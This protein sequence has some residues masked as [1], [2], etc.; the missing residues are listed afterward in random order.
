MRVRAAAYLLPALLVGTVFAPAVWDL[1][2]SYPLSTYPMFSRYREPIAWVVRALRVEADGR[3]T[4]VAPAVI[5]EG[6]P[7]QAIV[8]LKRTFRRG[9]R[10]SQELCR[11]ILA[12]LELGP[13]EA[14]E[15]RRDYIDAREH[16]A[17]PGAKAKRTRL[18]ARCESSR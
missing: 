6:E 1:D 14:I 13:D 18:V 4:P 8:T 7:M 9:R 2:D 3:A 11:E 12:R 5:A 16:F 10:A 15:L 17:D